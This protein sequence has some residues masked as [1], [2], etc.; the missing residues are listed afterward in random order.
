MPRWIPRAVQALVVSIVL[1]A[2]VAAQPPAPATP[3]PPPAPATA[4]P[5]PAA[6]SLPPASRTAPAPANTVVVPNGGIYVDPYHSATP[7]NPIVTNQHVPNPAFNRP[8]TTL[9]CDIPNQNLDAF[10]PRQKDC[11]R[12]GKGCGKGRGGC[13]SGGC[14]AGCG[15]HSKLHKATHPCEGSCSK[16]GSCT[17]CC[18]TN[19]FAFASSRSFFGESSREFF[20]RPASP[21]GIKMHPVKYA[22]PPAPAAYTPAYVVVPTP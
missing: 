2:A 17:T 7:Y 12:G 22:P 9:P 4:P 11:G 10:Q 16:G 15:G 6:E 3:P 1:P 8:W 18:N 21:D 19:N 20:E 13:N 14:D 5:P